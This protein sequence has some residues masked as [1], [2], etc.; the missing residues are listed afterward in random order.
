RFR[1]SVLRLR[2]SRDFERFHLDL[3]KSLA[4][5]W[6]AKCR[7]DL[8]LAH[9]YK[10]I[11]LWIKWLCTLDFGSPTMNAKL[12][13]YGHVP[14]DSRVFEA[15]DRLYCGIFVV[16]GRSMGHIRSGAAYRF[17]QEI[18]RSIADRLDL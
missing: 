14:I 6:K 2:N 1:R 9:R 10:L 8:S 5:H 11:D 12:L 13:E 18:V 4:K 17:W 7:K 3:T 15:I 16:S